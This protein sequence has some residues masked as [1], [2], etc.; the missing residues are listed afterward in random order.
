M[1]DRCG[2]VYLVGA[3]CGKADLITVRG[4]EL[5]A[6]CDTV[7]YD[8]LIDR[9]LLSYAPAEARRIYMGKRRGCHS[10]SQE[11]ISGVLV[12]E[13]KQG[14]TVVRLK[15]GDPFVFGR[16]GEEI[17]SLMENGIAFEVVPGISSAIAI[18]AEAGI[19]VTHRG[20]SRSF[21]V[22]TAH[23]ADREDG[24][25]EDLEKLAQLSGT[26]VFLMGLRQLPKLTKGLMEAG[27]SPRRPAAVVS[28]GSAMEKAAVRG[29]LGDIA[30]KAKDVRPPAVIVVGETA[31]MDL[32]SPLPLSGIRVG[33][34]GTDA[35]GKKLRHQLEEQGA[36]VFTALRMDVKP[37][38]VEFDFTAL[39]RTSSWVVFTSANGVACF[40]RELRNR[41]MDLRCLSKCRFAVIG[42]GTGEALARY[43]FRWDLC[44]ETYTTKALVKALMETG[45]REVPVYLM[46][47]ARGNPLLRECLQEHFDLEDVALYDVAPDGLSEKGLLERTDYLVFS[48]AGGAALFLERYGGIPEGAKC[49]CIGE[50][51]AKAIRGVPEERI[52]V[53]E[54][55]VT[56]SLVHAILKDQNR[57]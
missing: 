24:L 10:A 25:P 8:D 19:P 30:E 42:P 38:P 26:L 48:S 1:M 13:A 12:E 29:T 52:L 47:S 16:G 9:E 53:A 40:F 41:S 51:T 55:A 23:A 5:L 56:E 45:E 11:E 32:R 31:A 46:R 37:Q 49:V 34:V 44:P 36:E 15:G 54:K 7:V 20:V 22:I 57:L 21:H 3:G 14:R 4:R 6:R 39:E 50:M 18:P 33:I 2:K 28:G 17:L 43:G 35:V 27:M